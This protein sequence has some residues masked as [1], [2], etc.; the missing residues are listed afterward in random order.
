MSRH[1]EIVGA[2]IGGL[3][4]GIALRQAGWSVQVL[5]RGESVDGIGAGLSIWPNGVRSL[6]SLGLG[7]MADDEYAWFSDGALRRADASAIT[8]FPDSLEG[9]YG[10]PLVAI[11][12]GDLQNALA[13]KLGADSISFGAKVKEVGERG[14]VRLATGEEREADLV[15]G[16]DGLR[17]TARLTVIGAEEPRSSGIVAFR[18]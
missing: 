14:T 4:A 5:E 8:R 17:S 9:R 11:H 1:A 16:A 15:V 12:R 6:R 3:A 13:A 7:E 18:G 10:A 2:G